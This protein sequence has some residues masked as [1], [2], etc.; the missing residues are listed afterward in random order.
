MDN[1]V[2]ST[3]GRSGELI[4]YV[5]AMLVSGLVAYFTAQ[6]AANARIA[7]LETQ[8]KQIQEGDIRQIR[9]DIREIKSDV[10]LLL[11][12]PARATPTP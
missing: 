2:G 1:V 11:V 5:V 9:D 12:Q 7:V 10:R 4:R 8:V 3:N 6:N